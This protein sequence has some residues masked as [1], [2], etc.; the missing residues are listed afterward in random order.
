MNTA[1]HAKMK[2][3]GVAWGFRPKEELLEAGANYIV[4]D[5]EDLWRFIQERV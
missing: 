5:C 4:E 2:S 3:I 1:K